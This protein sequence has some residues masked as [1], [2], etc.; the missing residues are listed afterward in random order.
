[1]S[2]LVLAVFFLVASMYFFWQSTSQRRKSGLPAGK[3]IYADTS[4]WISV[5]KSLYDPELRLTGKPD[6]LVENGK[7]LIPVEVKSSNVKKVP[8]DSHIYQL[9]AY[10][11][12]VQKVYDKR[13]PYGILHYPDLTFTVDYTEEIEL[14]T[15]RVLERMRSLSRNSVIDRSHESKACCLKCSYRYICDQALK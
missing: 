8:Y 5:D 12:L 11:L 2:V 1:M 10:C 14:T 15:L 3:I 6:Y 9:A 7:D 4:N 13:P